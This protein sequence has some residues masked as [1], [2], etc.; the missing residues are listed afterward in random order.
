LVEYNPRVLEWAN[1]FVE[2]PITMHDSGYLVP[3]KP[4]LGIGAVTPPPMG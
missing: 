1:Q 3:S 4:G 2:H